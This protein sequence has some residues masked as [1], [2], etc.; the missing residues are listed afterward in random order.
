ME[1]W[2]QRRWRHEPSSAGVQG[3]AVGWGTG[4]S[5]EGCPWWLRASHLLE[6]SA[7]RV[8]RDDRRWRQLYRQLGLDCLVT[9]GY[10]SPGAIQ[11]LQ[12]AA[13]GDV[14]TVV[15][16]NSWKDV[17]CHPYVV[18]PPGRIGVAGLPEADHLRRWSPHLNAASIAVTGSLHLQRFLKPTRIIPRAEF[19]RSAGLDAGLPFLCYTAASPYAVAGEDLI[20]EELLQAIQHHRVRPQVLLRLNPREVGPRE[21]GGRFHALQQRFPGLVI[22][23]P[24]WEWDRSADWNALLREDVDHWVATVHHSAFNVSIPS[25]VTLEFAALGR[26][27]LNVCF[28]ANPP[29]PLETSNARFWDAPFYLQIRK[30]PFVAGAFSRQ[31]FRELLF[32]RLAEPGAWIIP[33]CR[34]ANLPVDAAEELVLAALDARNAAQPGYSRRSATYASALHL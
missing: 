33:P 2:G 3:P 20:V 22:Q 4:G 7:S 6:R 19:C 25:T 15:L 28:D 14:A 8:F 10:A 5:K 23:K 26:L 31:E 27:T 21:D 18:V 16:T 29:I 12:A 9:A 34:P 11:A 32:S 13:R 17:Y 30:S 24:R 1:G